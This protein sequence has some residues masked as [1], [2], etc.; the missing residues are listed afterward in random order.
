MT[1]D[2]GGRP[3]PRDRSALPD[4]FGGR[5][6]LGTMEDDV[7]G[8]QPTGHVGSSCDGFTELAIRLIA[9][10]FAAIVLTSVEPPV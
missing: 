5:D 2:K 8:R 3:R 4:P 10:G 7:S 1:T 6:P 9:Q